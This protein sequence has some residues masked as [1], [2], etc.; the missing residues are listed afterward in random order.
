MKVHDLKNVFLYN[1]IITVV[2]CCAFSCQRMPQNSRAETILV[3]IDD[4]VTISKNEFIRRA[5]YTIRPPYCKGDGYLHK[6][7]ILN[8]L[9]AEKLLALEAS[10]T[11][12][13]AQDNEFQRFVNGRKEQAMRQWMHHVEATDKVKPDSSEINNYFKFAGREYEIAYFA[14]RDTTSLEQIHQ[15]FQNSDVDSVF[16][17]RTVKWSDSEAFPVLE[18]L[19][20]KQIEKGQILPPIKINKNEFLVTKVLGW[21]DTKMIT[22]QQIQERFRKVK[23]RLVTEK[24]GMIWEKVVAEIM[25]GKTIDFNRPVFRKMSDIFYQI[26]FKTSEEKKN[27]LN[28][29]IWDMEQDSVFLPDKA[30]L[31][32]LLTQSFFT[33]DDQV[34]TVDDF[35]TELMSH[36]L[37]FRNR[38]MPSSEFAKE[39][40]LAVV[41]LI[42]DHYVTKQ[43]YKKGYDKVAVVS[44]NADMWRDAYLAQYQKQRYLHSIRESRQFDK[45]FMSIIGNH[46]NSYVDS[47]QQK[48]YQKIR[49]NVDEFE[50]IPL[51]RIDVLVKQNDQP[52]PY[53]VPRFPVLTTDH[54]IEYVTKM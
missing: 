32:Q 52:Y 17:T 34:W 6:K 16:P 35:R 19:F 25:K 10:D 50:S 26:Y 45:H 31:E 30:E 8:S 29:H 38:K 14:I 49:L 4:K 13:L 11:S 7:I 22:G 33:I 43:A 36:P 37:V 41:D 1:L 3:N 27:K 15:A 12:A 5:E 23:E 28:E 53:L 47:L 40:R 46:L 20:S 21:T 9:I 18:S 44:R 39:F 2:I 54:L 42:R 51:T 24:A 48:Y